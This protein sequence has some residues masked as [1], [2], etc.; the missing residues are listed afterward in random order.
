MA[1]IR[2]HGLGAPYEY[3]NHIEISTIGPYPKL[4]KW[5]SLVTA[6]AW[7]YSAS[8]F[9]GRNCLLEEGPLRTGLSPTNT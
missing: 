5:L 2:I 6:Q 9:S 4:P 1:I 8:H 3:D 7:Q